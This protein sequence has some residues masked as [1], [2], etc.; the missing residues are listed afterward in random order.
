MNLFLTL[1]LG[2]WTVIVYGDIT[3]QFLALVKK[4]S[5]KDV[6]Y[7]NIKGFYFSL[8]LSEKCSERKVSEK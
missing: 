4:I 5:N 2:W 6:K 8:Y 7:S 3:N 1:L